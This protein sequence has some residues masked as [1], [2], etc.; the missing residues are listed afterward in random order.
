MFSQI[1]AITNGKN[2]QGENALKTL[3][4]IDICVLE[5]WKELGEK[6]QRGEKSGNSWES[7]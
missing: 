3:M 4:C 7:W 2:S 5:D 6:V 1:T